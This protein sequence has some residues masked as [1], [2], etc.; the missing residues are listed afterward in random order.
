MDFRSSLRSY[1]KSLLIGY[2]NGKIDFPNFVTKL[3]VMC[4]NLKNFDT[5]YY[6]LL[7]VFYRDLE[8]I[9]ALALA[10]LK[11]HPLPEH[12]SSAKSILDDLKKVLEL[13]PA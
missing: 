7:I 12:E 9:N 8:E 4:D 13:W 5:D 3:Q 1:I 10:E 6:N 11:Y 2:E